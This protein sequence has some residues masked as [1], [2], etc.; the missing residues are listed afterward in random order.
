MVSILRPASSFQERGAPPFTH[1]DSAAQR[2]FMSPR[3]AQLGTGR[4]RFGL[5]LVPSQAQAPSSAVG[6][7]LSVAVCQQSL[8]ATSRLGGDIADRVIGCSW[9]CGVA[10]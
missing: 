5:G 3:A 2:G 4:A 8:Q 7:F 10:D 9:L 6:T 1:E